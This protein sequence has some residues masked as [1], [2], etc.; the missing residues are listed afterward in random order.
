MTIKGIGTVREKK[1][2]RIFLHS[3]ASPGPFRDVLWECCF[4]NF[5]LNYLNLRM[6]SQFLWNRG[7]QPK[8]LQLR[9]FSIINKLYLLS[10]YYISTVWTVRCLNEISKTTTQRQKTLQNFPSIAKL[11]LAGTSN[12]KGLIYCFRWKYQTFHTVIGSLFNQRT[13]R[14]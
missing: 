1:I 12:T 8:L 5:L 2:L 9:N 10:Y 3:T 6:T 11:W 4:F 7:N 13:D 14:M